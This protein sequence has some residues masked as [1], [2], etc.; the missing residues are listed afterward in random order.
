MPGLAIFLK[1]SGVAKIDSAK[2]R[3]EKCNHVLRAIVVIY[4]AQ[5]KKDQAREGQRGK[6][7]AVG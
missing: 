4:R 7:G 2:P 1:K 5:G 6:V 3:F